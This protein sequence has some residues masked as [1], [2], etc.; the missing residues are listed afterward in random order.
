M[1]WIKFKHENL[2]INFLLPLRDDDLS[3]VTWWVYTSLL[4][5][6]HFAGSSYHSMPD[7]NMK[8]A[9]ISKY[10][11]NVCILFYE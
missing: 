2:Y 4:Q 8:Y 11:D 3:R 9:N 5:S 6:R 1:D 7:K 10:S